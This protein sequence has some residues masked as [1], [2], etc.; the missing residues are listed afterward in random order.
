M[1]RRRPPPCSPWGDPHGHEGTWQRAGASAAQ[2][3]DGNKDPCIEAAKNCLEIH[4]NVKNVV[5]RAVCLQ[6]LDSQFQEYSLRVQGTL[7]RSVSLF[8]EAPMFLMSLC[9]LPSFVSP[10]KGSSAPMWSRITSHMVERI[11]GNSL[12]I[13]QMRALPDVWATSCSHGNSPGC[14]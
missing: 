14:S 4:K 7:T 3:E 6:I 9:F 13:L 2:N 10:A 8:L 12:C 11:T 1:K 5:F